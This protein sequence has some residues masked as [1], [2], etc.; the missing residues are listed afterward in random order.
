MS[1]TTPTP[2]PDVQRA[3]GGISAPAIVEEVVRA[4]SPQPGLSWLD[5][6]CGTGDLLR[7]IRDRHAPRALTGIDAV[8]FLA[9]DLC[10]DV[11]HRVGAAESVLADAKPADRVLLVETIEHLEAPWTILRMAARLVAPRGWLVVSTPNVA[12]LRSRLNLLARGE[13]CYFRADN[14][15]HLTPA[16]P[17]VTRRILVEEGLRVA[18]PT[19][20]GVDVVPGTGGRRW[21]R[22]LA[23]RRPDLACI[24]VV[25]AASRP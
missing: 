5:V 21:P 24:S 15:P 23:G 6:G 10:G 22:A 12:A 4:A 25:V 16:L 8:D 9:P 17:H 20:A 19:Y 13:L 1:P 3:S 7:L 2:N 11:E 14:L 18:E